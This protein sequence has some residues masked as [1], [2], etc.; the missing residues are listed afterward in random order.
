MKTTSTLAKRSEAKSAKQSF[1]KENFIYKAMLRF[2]LLASL[3]S[4]IFEE[5]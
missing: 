5:P 3:Y 2:S 4:A 1:A